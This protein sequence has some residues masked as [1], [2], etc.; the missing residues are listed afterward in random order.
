MADGASDVCDR[1]AAWC[2][3]CP[4]VIMRGADG[5]EPGWYHVGTREHPGPRPVRGSVAPADV[6]EADTA[7][8]GRYILLT[9]SHSHADGTLLSGSRKGDGVWEIL[10]PLGWKPFRS[11]ACLGL[12]NSRDRVAPRQRITATKKALE[13]A[14]FEAV[15]VE[16]DDD[17]RDRA[18]VLAAQAERLD[19]RADRLNARADRHAG[20][21]DAARNRAHEIGAR[22]EGGQ[23]ILN[24]HHS[25]PRA[26]RD[27][28]RMHDADRRSAVEHEAAQHVGRQ[29]AAVGSHAAHAAQP[30]ATARRIETQ[31]K[32]L[33]DLVKHLDGRDPTTDHLMELS[34][35][36]VQL[37]DRIAFDRAQVQAAIDAG[38]W[39]WHNPRTVHVGDVVWSRGLGRG[40]IMKVNRTTVDVSCNMPWPLKQKFT[41]II[42]VVCTHTTP[43]AGDGVQEEK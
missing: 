18:T 31:E 5:Q 33:R 41:Q 11:L 35:R 37:K 26:R 3:G 9:I 15:V 29:A 4:E 8:A 43:E 23:P 22:F 40:L 38:E 28:A 14:G 16:I 27:Q 17:I 12:P 1:I 36:I 19:D 13:A 34:A 21:A 7:R 39:V 32:E 20:N 42:R 30:D 10:S 25:E 2:D 24:G 6:W